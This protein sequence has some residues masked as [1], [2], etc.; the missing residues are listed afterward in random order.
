M[1]QHIVGEVEKY[2]PFCKENF[3]NF[4]EFYLMGD[5]ILIIT[6]LLIIIDFLHEIYKYLLFMLALVEL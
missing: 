6:N 5:W 2:V 1:V 3:L 4:I